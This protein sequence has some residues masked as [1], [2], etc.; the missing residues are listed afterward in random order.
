MQCVPSERLNVTHSHVCREVEGQVYLRCGVSLGV[1]RGGKPSSAAGGWH[2]GRLSSLWSWGAEVLT[3]LRFLLL[4]LR[5]PV[6]TGSG[7][8]YL[9]GV[10]PCRRPPLHTRVRVRVGVSA[11]GPA[12]AQV[13]GQAAAWP[14]EQS[15]ACSAG[16][17]S[18]WAAV[19]C[20]ARAW[21]GNGAPRGIFLLT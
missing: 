5:L 10:S 20:G 17:L 11:E 14:R 13:A 16:L 8:G 18:S 15:V 9:E 7:G 2:P 6:C 19:S 21:S 12:R 4:G 1:G 3:W